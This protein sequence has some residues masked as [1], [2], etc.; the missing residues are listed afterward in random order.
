M[1]LLVRHAESEANA[2]E[3]TEF[4][5]EAAL[6]ARGLEQARALAPTLPACDLVIASSYA[7][8]QQTAAAAK[9]RITEIWPVH[10][11]VYL[12]QARCGRSTAAE[13]RPHV[14]AYWARNDPHYRDG[15]DVESFAQLLGR[16]RSMLDRL[17]DKA[18]IVFTHG[19][20]I[21]A[22]YWVVLCGDLDMQR[23][24]AFAQCLDVPNTAQIR[25]HYC[26]GAWHIGQPKVV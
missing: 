24:R 20:F 1:I 2:G 13:R 25:L 8:T 26:D 15:A 12:T 18:A 10:E 5:D 22:V 23:F 11:F 4:P 7:R 16:V 6:T 9:Q 3:A 17:R 21:K 14:E 19:L